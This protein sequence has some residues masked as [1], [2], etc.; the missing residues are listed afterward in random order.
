MADTH[1]IEQTDRRGL[2]SE[3]IQE[4]S[5]REMK[6]TTGGDSYGMYLIFGTSPATAQQQSTKNREVEFRVS[7]TAFI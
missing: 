1:G 4:L 7:N 2:S 3:E 5:Q 6:D